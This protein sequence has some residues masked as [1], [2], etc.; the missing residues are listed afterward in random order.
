MFKNRKYND[1]IAFHKNLMLKENGQVYAM[2]EV[3][4]MN[5]SRTDE[6]AKE[7]AKAIQHSAFLELIPYHNGEILT[8]PMNL[9][10]FSRY[11]VLSDDLADD[12]REVAE[13]MFDG[14]LDLFAE[15]MGAPYEYR[16]FMVIPLKNNFIS[17]N[18]IKTIKT[19]F[20]Q[21]KAQAMGYLKEKQF[22]EDWYEEYEGLNDTLSSTLSTLD[23]KPTNG[24][25]T[26]FINRYQYLRGLY[27]NREHEV[28][29]LENS[30]SNL[31]EVRKKYFVDGTSRLGNDYGESVVKVLPIAYLPNNV[32]YFHLVEYIQTM[33]FP[34]E[35]NTKYYFNKRK[36]WNSIKKKAERALGRLKQTQ[37]EAY[38]K[39]SI[40]NDN[41]G[42]SVEVLGDVI[43]RDNANEVFLSYLMTLIITGESVE[44]V[45]WKQNHLMEKMKAYNVELSSAMGD[46][47]Y[48]LDKLTFAS[49]LLAT[50]KNWIQPMSIES[51]CENL[52]FVT[53]KV[54]FDYGFYLGRVDGSSRNYG[55]D[56]K[57]ALADSNN[58]VFVNPFAVNKDILGKVTNNPATDV[59]GETGAGKSFLAKLLFL[60]MTLMKSK[61]FYID[62]KAEMRNQY[63]KVMEEYK[64][65]PI[66][67]DDASEK[68]IWSYNFKQAIVRYI[69][70]INFI[71]FDAEN[72]NNHG[73]LD[74]IVFL[75]GQEAIDLSKTLVKQVIP[76]EY[77]NIDFDTEFPNAV[78]LFLE[79]RKSGEQVGLLS[80]FEYL[81]DSSSEGISK[82]AKYLIGNSHR[83]VLSLIFSNGQN[84]AISMD[85][86]ITILEVQGLT[87]PRANDEPEQFTDAQINSLAI[88]YALGHFCTWF[89]R[90]DKSENTST[91][92]DEAWFLEST[93][94]GAHILKEKRRT[95]R[96]YNDFTFQVSQSVKDKSEVQGLK[97]S[98]SFGQTF[99]FLEPNE[100][101]EELDYL[102]IPKTDESRKMMN[103]MTRAQCVY[104]DCFGRK[105]RM[106]VDGVFPEIAKLFETQEGKNASARKVA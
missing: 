65:A 42:A 81:E 39:D 52:F 64:N 71:T 41:I 23:A 12:T 13:Y 66:P 54:G 93:P 89:G 86:R 14:T 38:E 53:E 9:D 16:Y 18:L 34:V 59:T 72:E 105:S 63:L 73:V 68:E 1:I 24:E 104:K 44:E 6:Q 33:P 26:K 60:Y 75:T 78:E 74:P 91:L 83:S 48:L 2:F 37:I 102:K 25:Q 43:Q 19:T 11:Q 85:S 84:K 79:K 92:F 21:L 32:S 10:V 106:T 40:Q 62:P 36:G 80:V 76:K 103:T 97:D 29:M 69:E 82:V 15:E 8:L 49:D 95:G 46:Q 99:A 22:F 50:D 67:D 31:E 27:Y 88:M 4:A 51:F 87:L 17:T 56:F 5:L 70:K 90:R 35:V 94:I 77:R 28:N 57:Q 55:G 7:T 101:D 30:I 58:L 98:T 20:E 47:P 3:P 100:V 96:S 45:E 61:N